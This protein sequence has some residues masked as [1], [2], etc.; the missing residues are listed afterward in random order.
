MA[1]EQTQGDTGVAPQD[2]SQ[3]VQNAEPTNGQTPADNTGGAGGESQIDPQEFQRL[4]RLENQYKGSVNLANTA[5]NAGFKT[6]DEIQTAAKGAQLL[7]KLQQRGVDPDNIDSILSGQQPASGAPQQNGQAQTNGQAQPNGGVLDENRISSI[8]RNENTKF[9]SERDHN[10]QWSQMASTLENK[11]SELSGG[12]ESAE[13]FLQSRLRDEA[14]AQMK[15]Y[16]PG[17][18]LEGKKRPLTDQEIE[19]VVNSVSSE[20]QSIT[21]SGGNGATH[22]PTEAAVNGGAPLQTGG[23]T[24]DNSGGDGIAGNQAYSELDKDGKRERLK[25][26]MQ[27]KMQQRSPASAAQ[28]GAATV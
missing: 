27:Q 7:A 18:P 22:N 6:P 4:Q 25:A 17:S 11:L 13:R 14:L 16:P 28:G 20:Y 12:N 21:G 24:S 19:Q 9:H 26:L 3:Q 5:A 23:G 2:G 8:I 10:Q 15:P 1:D